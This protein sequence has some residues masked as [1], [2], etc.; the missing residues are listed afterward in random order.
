MSKS[1]IEST[2]SGGGVRA[3]AL[4]LT[5]GVEPRVRRSLELAAR[6]AGLIPAGEHTYY[7][8]LYTDFFGRIFKH[9][10]DFLNKSE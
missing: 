9:F 3:G 2:S 1:F 7:I 8:R 10:A 4:L 5:L 6:L